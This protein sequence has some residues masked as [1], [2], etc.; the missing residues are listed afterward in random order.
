MG[1]WHQ[2][3][4]A[5]W[6]SVVMW[7]RLRLWLREDVK[8]EP[9]STLRMNTHVHFFCLI[10]QDRFLNTA[11]L[12]NQDEEQNKAVKS[13]TCFFGGVGALYL[14]YATLRK[15]HTMCYK[16]WP[17]WRFWL[18]SY[19]INIILPRYDNDIK[20]YVM[21]NPRCSG[22]WFPNILTRINCPPFRNFS[23]WPLRVFTGTNAIICKV[24][25]IKCRAIRHQQA[26]F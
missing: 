15:R 20:I 8:G 11:I 2:D 16:R 13:E 18:L 12:F 19:V 3:W 21:T 25:M 24:C 6:L 14:M 5:D 1:T 4:L 22:Q 26:R 7:L 23:S 17:V 9:C 10:I